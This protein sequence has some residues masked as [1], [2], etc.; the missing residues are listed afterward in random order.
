MGRE[1]VAQNSAYL[2]RG[3]LVLPAP[4]LMGVQ[5]PDGSLIVSERLGPGSVEQISPEGT[6]YEMVTSVPGPLVP[7]LSFNE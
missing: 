2:R 7:P 5:G 6:V 1:I 4:D 3:T